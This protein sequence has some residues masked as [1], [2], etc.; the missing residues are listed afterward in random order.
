M[1]E[2]PE[3]PGAE[4][5]PIRPKKKGNG[6]QPGKPKTGGRKVGSVNKVPR[7][8]KEAVMLAAE[9]EGFDGRGLDGLT[10][11]MR[12]V[13]RDD[14]HGFVGLV[15]RAMGLQQTDSRNSNDVAVEVTYRSVDEVKRELASR[16]ID[17]EVVMKILES[18]ATVIDHEEEMVDDD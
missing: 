11:F 8:F 13:V 7:L 18:P 14:F 16:G 3:S 1:D 9:I 6:F 2:Q 15:G 5:V 12:R 4:I 17:L 10:G